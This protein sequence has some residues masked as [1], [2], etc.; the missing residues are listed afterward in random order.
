MEIRTVEGKGKKNVPLF[1]REMFKI[2][3]FEKHVFYWGKWNREE[4]RKY[5]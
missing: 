5:K 1:P 3:F 4:E 2:F